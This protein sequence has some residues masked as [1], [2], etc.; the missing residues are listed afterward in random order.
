MVV[1]RFSVGYS[2]RS[3]THGYFAPLLRGYKHAAVI[4]HRAIKSIVY[5][6]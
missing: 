2:L 4:A 6:R 5:Q 1:G 3:F